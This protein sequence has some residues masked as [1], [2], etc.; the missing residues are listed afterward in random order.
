MALLVILSALWV[1]WE[2]IHRLHDQHDIPPAWTLWIAGA[3]V[4]IKESLYQYKARVGKR[5]GSVAILANAWDHRSDALCA[6]AVL[7]G[8]GIV[9][10]GGPDFISAD[11]I[12]SLVVVAAIV[13]SGAALFRRSVHELMDVQADAD[14]LAAVRQ[15]AGSISG[16]QG[17]EKLWIRKSGLEFLADIHIEVDPQQTVAEGHRI[18]H[19][20]KDHLLNEFPRL[21]DVLV[22]LEPY[23]HHRDQLPDSSRKVPE[24]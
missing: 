4:V 13:W 5:T 14:F 24:T 15:S 17:V 12:A 7:V 19:V 10:W 3:N 20:V 1:G 8:L 16:V 21:R 23:P 2:A 22:H 9:R 11:E 18:G 6:F